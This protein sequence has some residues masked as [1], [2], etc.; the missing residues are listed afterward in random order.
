MDHIYQIVLTFVESLP[1]AVGTK[2]GVDATII[3]APQNAGALQ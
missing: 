2:F 1:L 3:R